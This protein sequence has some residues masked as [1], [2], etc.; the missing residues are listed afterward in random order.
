VGGTSVGYVVSGYRTK[1]AR[2]RLSR[3]SLWNQEYEDYTQGLMQARLHAAG[4]L[5]LEAEALGA[6]G[7]LGIEFAREREK[8][9]DDNLLV[10]VD[11]LGT[12]IAPIDQGAPPEITY[13]IRL[14]KT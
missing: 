7:V 5:R 8:Q 14:G 10:T 2:F 6:T 12:A 11:L 4:R 9:S 1:W 3:R 13:A